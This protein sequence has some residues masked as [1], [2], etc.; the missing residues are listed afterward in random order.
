M[1]GKPLF[2]TVA[3]IGIGLI[4]SSLARVIRR[5]GLANRIVACARSDA[6]LDKVMELGLADH[7]T[8]D[9]QEAAS[10]A[11]LIV[12]CTPIGTCGAIAEAIAPVLKPGQI[13]TDV[14]SVKQAVITAVLP[15]MP[16]GVAFVPGHPVAGTENSGPE[17]GFDTLFEDRRFIMTPPDGSDEEAVERVA[18]LWRRAGSTVDRMSA[19]HHDWVLALT[20]HLPTLIAFNIVGTVD[21]LESSTKQEVIK[22]SA[23]GFR[24][25]T[26][27]AAQDPDMWR[28]VFLNNR[29]AMLEMLQRFSED[30]S[31]LQRAI[32]WGE[33]EALEDLIR[34]SRDIRRNVIDAG[35]A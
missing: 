34:R 13:V 4:G 16:E 3:F 25:M 20:S 11:D 21:D 14:G 28:D 27:L 33:A 10:G 1:T 9:L 30:L 32:R 2:E 22:Y 29:E 12:L 17:S 8:K 26:R 6:T 18:E 19:E 23:S 24:D 35:Q 31:R 5:D 15:H 7:V